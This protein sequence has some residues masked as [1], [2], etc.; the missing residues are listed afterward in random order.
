MAKHATATTVKVKI[1]LVES[2]MAKFFPV[3]FVL[4]P[5][6]SHRFLL[7]YTQVYTQH[8]ISARVPSRNW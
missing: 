1:L 7:R 8:G 3:A 4:E 6:A 2:L 5:V